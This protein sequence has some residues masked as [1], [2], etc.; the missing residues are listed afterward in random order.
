MRKS[1]PQTLKNL[2]NGATLT[3]IQERSTALA[4]LNNLIYRYIPSHLQHCCRVANYRQSVLIIEVSSASWLTRLRYEQEKLLSA[5]RQN[6]LRSLAS[7]QYKIN[8]ILNRSQYVMKCNPKSVTKR[9]ITPQSASL[10]LA[11]SENT[12]PK[13]KT[14]LIKLANH[15][16]K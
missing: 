13:L 5:L 10:L 12:T 15:V 11:L 8:P 2:F 9:V 16:V 7:I 4:R 3:T 14:N 6:G 1:E